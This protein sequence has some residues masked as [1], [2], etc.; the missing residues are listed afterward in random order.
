V[1]KTARPRRKDSSTGMVF[2]PQ[3]HDTTASLFLPVIKQWLP[4]KKTEKEN[5]IQNFTL[6]Q[7]ALKF[8][9]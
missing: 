2:G 1:V 7:K 3:S 4:L 9:K 6:G 8:R 5:A